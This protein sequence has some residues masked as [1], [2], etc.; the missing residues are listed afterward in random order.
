MDRADIAFILWHQRPHGS[1]ADEAT[2]AA[3][4]AG[5]DA[6][7]LSFLTAAVGEFVERVLRDRPSGSPGRSAAVIGSG[8]VFVHAL[9]RAYPQ[10]SKGDVLDLP[11]EQ[12]WGLYRCIQMEKN[13]ES[14][15]SNP[16]SDRVRSEYQRTRQEERAAKAAREARRAAWRASKAK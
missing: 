3:F 7:D 8:A 16:L 1:A 11:L 9:M 10:M 14:L 2:L 13:P 5:F 15:F 6:Q 12:M 4:K